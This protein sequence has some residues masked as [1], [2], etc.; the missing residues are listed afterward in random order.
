MM[1][2]NSWL[3]IASTNIYLK[4]SIEEMQANRTIQEEEKPHY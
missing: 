3:Y 4:N 2:P 1:K